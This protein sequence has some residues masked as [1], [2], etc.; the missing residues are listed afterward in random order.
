MQ[1][2]DSNNVVVDCPISGSKVTSMIPCQT[3]GTAGTGTMHA[4]VEA[5]KSQTVRY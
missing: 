4:G 2:S 3:A 1:L 5:C